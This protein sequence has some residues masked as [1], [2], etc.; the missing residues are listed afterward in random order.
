MKFE[1]VKIIGFR[2]YCFS[3]NIFYGFWE[4]K[5]DLRVKI[6]EIK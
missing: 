6:V 3:C 4:C 1:S 2:E 5:N